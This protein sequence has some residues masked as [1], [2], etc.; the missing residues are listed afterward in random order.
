MPKQKV[1]KCYEELM[2]QYRKGKAEP[3]P[4]AA[5]KV[6]QAEVRVKRKKG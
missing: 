6:K 2:E 5:K 3:K 4:R 1:G